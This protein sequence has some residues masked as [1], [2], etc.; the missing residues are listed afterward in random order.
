[1]LSSQRE[2]RT[3]EIRSR[4]PQKF[5]L[6]LFYARLIT[7]LLLSAQHIHAHHGAE[8][9]SVMLLIEA[10]RDAQAVRV[11]AHEEITHASPFV[12]DVSKQAIF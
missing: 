2:H 4:K 1:M 8:D 9:G 7:V 10:R 5:P 3:I 12:R 11:F 6:R